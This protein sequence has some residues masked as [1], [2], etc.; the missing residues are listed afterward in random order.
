[1]LIKVKIFIEVIITV[2]FL[3]ILIMFIILVILFNIISESVEASLIRC[4]ANVILDLNAI[5]IGLH[6]LFYSQNHSS[7]F[8]GLK[9]LIIFVT[10][11][12]FL[13]LFIHIIYFLNL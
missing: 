10:F 6:R 5:F 9:S 13:Y 2:F 4:C 8:R 11:R 1:V 3:I 12:L 7:F